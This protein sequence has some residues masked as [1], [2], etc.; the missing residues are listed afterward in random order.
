M[1]NTQIINLLIGNMFR[2]RTAK[3]DG[4]YRHQ[5]SLCRKQWE[6]WVELVTQDKDRLTY[7]ADCYQSFINRQGVK[8]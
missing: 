8:Q 3:H 7:Y 2:H 5:C 1:S 4:A 6:R